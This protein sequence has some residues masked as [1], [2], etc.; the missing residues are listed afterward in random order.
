LAIAQQTG[1]QD[2]NYDKLRQ[3]LADA[4][5]ILVWTGKASNTAH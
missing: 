1:V 5:Q 2:V 3:Q 4:G